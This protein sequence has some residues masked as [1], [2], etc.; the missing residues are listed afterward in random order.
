MN[1]YLIHNNIV[2][3]VL[4]ITQPTVKVLESCFDSI[5]VLRIEEFHF[6]EEI[7]LFIM[8]LPNQESALISKHYF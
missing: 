1:L 6:S 7:M 2:D 8:D 4:V 5:L 3:G